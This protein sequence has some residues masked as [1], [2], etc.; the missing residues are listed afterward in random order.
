[1]SEA[2]NLVIDLHED[3]ANYYMAEGV[4]NDISKDVAGR[5]ADFPKYRRAGV[6]IVVASIFPLV[7]AWNPQLSDQLS[8]GYGRRYPAYTAK[9]PAGLALEQMKVYFQMEKAFP[10]SCRLIQT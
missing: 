4:E 9:G 7:R 6:V 2:S 3:V 1:M 10:N 5:Q 8:T